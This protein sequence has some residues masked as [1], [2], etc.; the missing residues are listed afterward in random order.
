M[1][2]S[3]ITAAALAVVSS[4]HADVDVAAGLKLY[5]VFDQGL[6]RQSVA[7]ASSTVRS[8]SNTGFFAAA[9]TS[10][11]GV[12]GERDVGNGYKGMVQFEQEIT[13]DESTLMPAKNRTAFVGLAP[14]P[15][16]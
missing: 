11:F 14:S 15:W 2:R 6:M 16:I 12:K 9:S 4:A 3:L 8:Y 13:P 7:S 10:R 5:G 1:N